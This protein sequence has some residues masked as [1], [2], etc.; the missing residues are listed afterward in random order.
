MKGVNF[1]VICAVFV[2]MCCSAALV[3]LGGDDDVKISSKPA[4]AVLSHWYRDNGRRFKKL[5]YPVDKEITVSTKVKESCKNR[6]VIIHSE[7][8]AVTLYTKGKVLYS[9]KD[10]GKSLYG[11]RTTVIDVSDISSSKELFLRLTPVTKGSCRITEPIYLTTNN[12]YIVT[13]LSRERATLTAAT[14]M[15]AAIIICLIAAAVKRNKK[16]SPFVYTACFMALCL[17]NVFCRSEVS[18]LLIGKNIARY[19]L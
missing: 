5:Y 1:I 10:G 2:L 19:M 13:M 3:S 15:L 9:T 4:H 14:A 11:N 6:C 18:Q 16:F 17:V 7:N 8:L 12:D